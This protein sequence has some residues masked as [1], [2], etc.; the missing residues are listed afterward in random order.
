M[1]RPHDGGTVN[2][3][4]SLNHYFWLVEKEAGGEAK[5][6]RNR[7]PSKYE[8]CV[9]SRVILIQVLYV[10]LNVP[11]RLKISPLD[12]I[13]TRRESAYD[14][15]T[16]SAFIYCLFGVKKYIYFLSIFLFYA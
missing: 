13:R 2:K 9:V 16:V 10:V 5:A 3:E 4:G 12:H 11:G 1:R 6:P 8:S 14:S 7:R 15:L